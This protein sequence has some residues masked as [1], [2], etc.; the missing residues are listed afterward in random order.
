MRLLPLFD[1]PTGLGVRTLL[2]LGERSGPAFRAGSV[3]LAPGQRVPAEGT[4][5]HAADEVSFI[6]A[7]SLSGVCG[8]LGF[9]T[10]AGE[11]SLIPAGE[12]HWAVAGPD[13]AEIF[14]CWYGDVEG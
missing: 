6:V 8:G 1:D 5:V 3:R 12:E 2:D 11:V 7:G 9:E 13:G 4:S 10:V 14:W